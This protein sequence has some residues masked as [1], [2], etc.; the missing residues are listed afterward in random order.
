MRI[1]PF[2][3][4]LR[5]IQIFG[6]FECETLGKFKE[7]FCGFWPTLQAQKLHYLLRFSPTG[8]D[9]L[10]V[11]LTSASEQAPSVDWSIW[12]A[13]PELMYSSTTGHLKTS[14]PSRLSR[15]CVIR[16]WM[17]VSWMVRT[18]P[19]EWQ[20]FQSSPHSTVSD[21]SLQVCSW[22][23]SQNWRFQ[24]TQKMGS[25]HTATDLD[26]LSDFSKKFRNWF[27]QFCH[28]VLALKGKIRSEKKS[29]FSPK[30]SRWIWQMHEK[31][32]HTIKVTIEGSTTAISIQH[33]PPIAIP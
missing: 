16:A 23:R 24:S 6:H 26:F 31:L 29:L 7:R 3:V 27:F 8:V 21:K 25:M 18:S 9:A 22:K 28:S 14:I 11:L 15:N 12:S 33:S 30:W 19:A 17:W 10:R 2:F 13:R 1:F 5:N 20:R 4:W 32:Q